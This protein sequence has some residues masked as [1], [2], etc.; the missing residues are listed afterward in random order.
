MK[1]C[2]MSY[3]PMC[4]LWNDTGSVAT[5]FVS[6][7]PGLERVIGGGKDCRK[8]FAN[9]CQLANPSTCPQQLS[10]LPVPPYYCSCTIQKGHLRVKP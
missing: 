1:T 8:W 3:P 9:K 4:I 5:E 10:S 2:I 7:N 6:R